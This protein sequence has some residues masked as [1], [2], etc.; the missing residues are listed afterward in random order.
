MKRTFRFLVPGSLVLG[1]GSAM[2]AV[3]AAVTDGLGEAATDIGTVGGL[4]LAA[5]IVFFGI[6]MIRRGLS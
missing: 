3:P 6:K 2:A 4:V 5:V 1:A